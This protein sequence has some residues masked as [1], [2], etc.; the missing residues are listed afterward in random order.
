MMQEAKST[1][2]GQW[3]LPAGKMEAGEDIGEAAKRE[4][5]E[6]TGLEMELS[7]FLLGTHRRPNN[8]TDTKP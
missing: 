7:T 2:A 5:L 8:C 4:V 3:Y 6:E 1:C